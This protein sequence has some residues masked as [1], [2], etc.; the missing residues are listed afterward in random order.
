MP[1]LDDTPA[2][3]ERPVP[4]RQWRAVANVEIFT[5]PDAP[6]T[7]LH[8]AKSAKRRPSV[9]DVGG[10]AISSP[11]AA[12]TRAASARHHAGR[13]RTTR[14]HTRAGSRRPA[15]GKIPVDS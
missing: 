6:L 9:V 13:T 7:K 4:R 15:T 8:A 2:G 10:G 3:I 1:R 11:T 5:P 14:A 12:A